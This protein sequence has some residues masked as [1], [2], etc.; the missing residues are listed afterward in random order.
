MENITLYVG[1]VLYNQKRFEIAE[2]ECSILPNG[3]YKLPEH[4][5]LPKDRTKFTTA[6]H[7]NMLDKRIYLNESK[8]VNFIFYSLDKNNVLFELVK[9]KEDYK[10]LQDSLIDEC[11]AEIEELK[12]RINKFSKRKD[13]IDQDFAIK[14][15]D[16]IRNNLR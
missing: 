14:P 12:K 5:S 16:R 13:A 6:I 10:K 7:S 3:M 1:L 11:M 2:Y 4:E 8:N 9:C 15:V